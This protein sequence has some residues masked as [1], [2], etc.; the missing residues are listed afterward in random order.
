M[1]KYQTPLPIPDEHMRMVG[2]I[3]AQW[4]WIELLLERA[5]AEVMELD[6]ERIAV[7]TTNLGFQTKCDIILG[8]IDPSLIDDNDE[9]KA[10]VKATRKR[11][12]KAYEGLK[13]AQDIRSRYVHTKWQVGDPDLPTKTSLRTI[14]KKIAIVDEPTP[15]D[16][17]YKAAEA[18]WAAGE[19][20]HELLQEFDLLQA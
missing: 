18:M 10:K 17:L 1:T 4:E 12:T 15:I 3:A 7:L 6:P 2:I 16:E 9:D 19:T 8:H 13:D 11:F 14:G 20:F 5:L